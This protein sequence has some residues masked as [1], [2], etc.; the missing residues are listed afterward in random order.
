MGIWWGAAAIV[1]IAVVVPPALR[2]PAAQGTEQE[3]RISGPGFDVAVVS[4]AVDLFT[5]GR[6]I[7]RFDT[8]GDE[9]FWGGTLRLH[10]AIEGER[11]GGVGPGLSPAA[12]LGVGL[13]VDAEALPRPC[14]RRSGKAA[15]T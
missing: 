8:F 5:R 15:S 4:H 12:A 3:A 9:Q 1:T 11:F 2:R 10:E 14:C 6:Q 13:K 7:F